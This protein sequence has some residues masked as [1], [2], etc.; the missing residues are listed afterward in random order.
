F[1][2]THGDRWISD[3]A[4]LSQPRWGRAISGLAS[5][6]SARISMRPELY[7]ALSA[8]FVPLETSTLPRPLALWRDFEFL[9]RASHSRTLDGCAASDLP[10][11]AEAAGYRW[12]AIQSL[13]E[14]A[15]CANAK[16][17]LWSGAQ[18]TE[19]ALTSAKH[20][21]FQLLEMR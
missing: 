16:G 13:L 5:L 11:R 20:V 14:L 15:T 3:L 17:L 18:L 9:F 6:A 21:H 2:K 10:V 19:R 7:R 4:A 12:L 1:L 8:E